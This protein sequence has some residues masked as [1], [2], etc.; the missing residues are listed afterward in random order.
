MKKKVFNP[1]VTICETT[2]LN[3]SGTIVNS[4][5]ECKIQEPGVFIIDC[6]C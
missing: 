4:L 3:L 2:E 5:V 1:I 6:G